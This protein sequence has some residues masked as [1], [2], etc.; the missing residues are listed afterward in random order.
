MAIKVTFV[1]SRLPMINDKSISDID[2]DKTSKITLGIHRESLS[3]LRLV[4]MTNRSDVQWP[5][6]TQCNCS[7]VCI[8]LK[9]GT[10]KC[11]CPNGMKETIAGDCIC[12][13]S[14]K[15]SPDG[16]CAER[17][18]DNFFRCADGPMIQV[19]NVCNNVTDCSDNSDENGCLNWT[20]DSNLFQCKSNGKCI[21]G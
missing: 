12:S 6:A 4:S 19:S 8:H 21:Q 20:C 10:F 7:H 3:P 11:L 14:E 16:I 1:T 18:N 2:Y 9:D 13:F 15:P 17:F 5:V